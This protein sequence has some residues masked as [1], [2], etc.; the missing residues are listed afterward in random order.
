MFDLK[1]LYL[2]SNKKLDY[3]INNKDLTTDQKLAIALDFISFVADLSELELK[4]LQAEK[5]D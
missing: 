4:A 3:L 5:K 2:M 1:T